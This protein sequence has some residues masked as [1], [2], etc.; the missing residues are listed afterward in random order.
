MRTLQAWVGENV[1]DRELKLV[2]NTHRAFHEG[3]LIK[4][5]S[6]NSL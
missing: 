4:W 3:Q 6:F 2:I 1:M 5:N